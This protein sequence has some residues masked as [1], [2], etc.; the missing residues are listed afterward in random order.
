MS[1]CFENTAPIHLKAKEKGKVLDQFL[2]G[3]DEP[4]LDWEAE[5][6]EEKPRASLFRCLTFGKGGRQ[7]LRQYCER[8]RLK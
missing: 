1:K 8:I 7:Q 3:E 5:M 2:Y 6:A 4:V